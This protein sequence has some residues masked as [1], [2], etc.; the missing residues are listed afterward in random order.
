MHRGG[1]GHFGYPGDVLKVTADDD[2]VAS[3]ASGV[4]EVWIWL[5]SPS[6]RADTVSGCVSAQV[7]AIF[8]HTSGQ[9]E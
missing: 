5:I 3:A 6:Q 8:M 1:A 4:V 9:R 7:D 2:G